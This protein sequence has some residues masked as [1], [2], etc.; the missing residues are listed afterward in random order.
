MVTAL[1]PPQFLTSPVVLDVDRSMISLEDCPSQ[2]NVALVHSFRVGVGILMYFTMTCLDIRHAA[3][4]LARVVHNP[5]PVHVLALDH[6]LQYLANTS[7]LAFLMVSSH[8][9]SSPGG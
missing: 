4:Q 9:H 6:R 1:V 5:G 2:L 3:H 8:A 7:N